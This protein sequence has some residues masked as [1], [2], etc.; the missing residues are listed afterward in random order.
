MPKPAQLPEWASD[1]GTT[2]DPGLVICRAGHVVNTRLAARVFNWWQNLVWLWLVYLNN[3][4]SENH[5]Y[6][7]SNTFVGITTGPTQANLRHP[8]Y[9]KSF[10]VGS[11]NAVGGSTPIFGGSFYRLLFSDGDTLTHVRVLL[12]DAVGTT[13]QF[14]VY[15]N[16]VAMVGGTSNV[17]TGLGNTGYIAI[18][19]AIA[20]AC[21]SNDV[22]VAHV[23]RVSGAGSGSVFNGEYWV[24]RV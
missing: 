1:A 16:N 21:N 5:T 24:S 17:S 10:D 23:S 2:F 6:V 9:K 19:S 22:V 18:V 14:T 3:F 12:T 11:P 15:K 20:I 13:Y 8:Q 4:E 7:G